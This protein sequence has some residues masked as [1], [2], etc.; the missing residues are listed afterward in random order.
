MKRQ[1]MLWLVVVLLGGLCFVFFPGRSQMASAETA[2]MYPQ[3]QKFID[4]LE[5]IEKNY[6]EQVSPERLVEGAIQG[7][8]VVL[9]P[10]STYLTQQEYKDIKISTTGTFGGLG[11]EIGLRDGVLTVITPMEG[12]PAFDAGLEPGDRIIRIGEKSTSDMSLEKAVQLLRGDKGTLVT[13]TISRPDIRQS[14]DI[15]ITRE[16]IHV[17]SVRSRMIE[18]GYG[19]IKIRTFQVDTAQDVEKAL[20]NMDGLKGLVL[21]LR[22]DPGGLLDQAIKVSDLFLSK[23]Q[24]VY[25]DGRRPGDKIKYEAHSKESHTG[26]PIIVLINGGTASAAEIVAGALQD[27]GRAVIL[28]VK[29]FGKASVQTI[30]PLSDGSALKLTV[31]RYYTPSGRSIQA[32]GID[33]DIRVEQ[34]TFS[35]GDK[36]E[37]MFVREKDLEGHLSSDKQKTVKEKITDGNFLQGDYQ[38][39]YAFDLLK[40]WNVFD[41]MEKAS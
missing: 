28:G 7:M 8:T 26:F 12:T 3:L 5:F 29:S 6:V 20:D 24:I 39:Q 35:K 13:I 23:G 21:D 9:D 40:T 32:R 15:T 22:Y 4:C 16:I 31:A 25:T 38:I 33:P 30:R 37:R 11:I 17:R 1:I 14:F 41:R 34:R 19:Y 36:G 2:Q 27:N 18:K 10:H